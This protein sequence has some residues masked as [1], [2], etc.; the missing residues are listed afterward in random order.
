MPPVTHGDE[1]LEH[2]QRLSRLELTE[3]E[4]AAF[5]ADL[6]LLLAYLARLQEADLDDEPEWTPPL[7]PASPTRPDVVQP[8]LAREMALGLAPAAQDGFFR[9]PRTLD[10]G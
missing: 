7:P 3:E 1:R 4:A 10:D 2:L 9:V 8:S 5:S 6:D